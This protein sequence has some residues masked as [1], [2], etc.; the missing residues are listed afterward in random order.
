MTAC[1]QPR[2]TGTIVDGYCDVCGSPA[3]AAP[4]V[5]AGSAAS[6]VAPV[7]AV[8][9]G[10]TALGRGSGVPPPPNSGRMP[11]CTQPGCTGT[12]VDG[13]CDVCGGPVGAVP[14]VPAETAASAGSPAPADEPGLTA[15]YRRP[16]SAPKPKSGSLMTACAQPECTGM[17]VDG[18]CDVCGSPANAVPFVP[19]AASAES[20]APADEPGLM[21]CRRRYPHLPLLTRRYPPS[22]F[23]G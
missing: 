22:G 15:V 21:R 3:V 23:L 8:E 2:C 16:G 14:F 17:I 1:T 19:A 12:I 4:F 10:I 5:P 6:A 9:A 20:P 18:Y 11:A 7:H 13:Y